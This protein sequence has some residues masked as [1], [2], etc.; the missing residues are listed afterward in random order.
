MRKKFKVFILIWVF[1]V[2][3]TTAFIAYA[4]GPP[5]P[6]GGSGVPI[7]GS[8]LVVLIFGVAL[9]VRKFI[10]SEDSRGI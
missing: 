4:Q 6:P 2:L 3:P 1:V 8:A 5:P 9:A 10:T 7:D